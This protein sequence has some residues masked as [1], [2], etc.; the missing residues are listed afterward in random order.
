MS[1]VAVQP[2]L[3]QVPGDRDGSGVEPFRGQRAA[4]HDDPF[5][6][7]HGDPLRTGQRCPGTAAQAVQSFFPVPGEQLMQVRPA[8]PVLRPPRPSR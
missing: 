5:P 6:H 7:P 3:L 2:F 4:Q 1:T 8:Q